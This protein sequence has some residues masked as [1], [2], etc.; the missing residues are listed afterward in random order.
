MKGDSNPSRSQ[1]SGQMAIPLK[2]TRNGV[3]SIQGENE[4]SYT[5][6]VPVRTGATQIQEGPYV[7]TS[8]TTPLINVVNP[9][10]LLLMDFNMKL[11]RRPTPPRIAGKN[12]TYDAPHVS[13]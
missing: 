2:D 5:G 12:R 1:Y 11:Y 13:L 7:P 4:L 3:S 9:N 6:P 10:E 8:N